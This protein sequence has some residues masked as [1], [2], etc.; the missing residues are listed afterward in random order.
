VSWPPDKCVLRR[1]ASGGLT[2]S[3]TERTATPDTTKQFCLCRVWRGGV[4]SAIAIDVSTLQMFCRRVLSCRECNSHRRSG[5]DTDKT[6]L[7]CTTW[8]CLRV[9]HDA[10]ETA[11]RAGASATADTCPLLL[12]ARQQRSVGQFL[13]AAGSSRK[14]RRRTVGRTRSAVAARQYAERIPRRRDAERSETAPAT[15]SRLARP[16]DMHVASEQCRIYNE[17]TDRPKLQTARGLA[18]SVQLTHDPSDQSVNRSMTHV[19]ISYDFC[20]SHTW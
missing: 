9:R 19:I 6:V 8:R 12:Q 14:R 10:H 4:N 20:L 16:L 3:D 15:L 17:N 7:S 1:S 11:H 2:H 18:F 13:A 5:R